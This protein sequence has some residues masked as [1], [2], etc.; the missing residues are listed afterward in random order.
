MI[1]IWPGLYLWFS[2][3]AYNSLGNFYTRLILYESNCTKSIRYKLVTKSYPNFGTYTYDWILI[4]SVVLFLFPLIDTGSVSDAK[5]CIS[6]TDSRLE[7]RIHR[8][9]NNFRFITPAWAVFES[10]FRPHH[11]LNERM[12]SRKIVLASCNNN[13]TTTAANDILFLSNSWENWDAWFSTTKTMDLLLLSHEVRLMAYQ[14]F[15]LNVISRYVNPTAVVPIAALVLPM[16]DCFLIIFEALFACCHCEFIGWNSTLTLIINL[17]GLV[18]SS[19]SVPFLNL[20][21]NC[22]KSNYDHK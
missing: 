13:R 2:Y 16:I 5:P 21:K 18:V 20:K 7:I 9:V 15:S 3:G 1:D 6:D 10:K 11:G 8:I 14:R 19:G 22:S 17:F 4:M 12:F